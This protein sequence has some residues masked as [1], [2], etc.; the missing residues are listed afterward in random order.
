[1]RLYTDWKYKNTTLLIASIALLLIFADTKIVKDFIHSIGALGYA[2]AFLT[3]IFFVST[4]TVAP[5]TV[6]LYY[7]SQTLNPFGVALCA[8]I[9]ALVGDYAIFRFFKDGVFNELAPLGRRISSSTLF[10][11]FKT[12]YFIWL[13]PFL[14][15]FIIASPL[16]DELGIALLGATRMKRWKFAL[17]SFA[18]NTAG[19]LIIVLVGR[20]TVSIK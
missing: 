17:L 9:G 20:S 3:G 11:L 10:R 4:F 12:P 2:G 5:A 7:F 13:M 8:G 1:M 6:T 16:P 14:G 18:L 15:A 19:I